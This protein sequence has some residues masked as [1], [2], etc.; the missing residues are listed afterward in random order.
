MSPRNCHIFYKPFSGEGNVKGQKVNGLKESIV[1][2]KLFC[3]AAA[4]K[5]S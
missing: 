2:K 3:T 4:C 5:A 1:R